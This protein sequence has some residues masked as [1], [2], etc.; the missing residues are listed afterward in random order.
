MPVTQDPARAA[1]EAVRQ[2]TF[3]EPTKAARTLKRARRRSPL[4]GPLRKAA[5]W[6]PL[7]ALGSGPSARS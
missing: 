2:P 3:P 1:G 5:I 7:A 4:A 6:L